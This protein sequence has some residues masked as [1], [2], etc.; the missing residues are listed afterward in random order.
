MSLDEEVLY[1]ITIGIIEKEKEKRNIF[2]IFQNWI[3]EDIWNFKNTN[4]FLI[5]VPVNIFGLFMAEVYDGGNCSFL[6]CHMGQQ[7][8]RT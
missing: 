4:V 5:G 2:G 3:F 1:F 6:L 7:L 8:G